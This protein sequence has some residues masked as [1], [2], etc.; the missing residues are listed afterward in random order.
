MWDSHWDLMNNP[1]LGVIKKSLLLLTSHVCS[2]MSDSF[3]TPETA[4]HQAPLSMGFSRYEYWSGLPFP[5]PGGLSNTGIELMYPALAG[6]FFTT[7]PPGKW[8]MTHASLNSPLKWP[9]EVFGSS[10]WKSDSGI[11]LSKPLK[12][13]IFSNEAW[14]FRKKTR[15]GVNIGRA[16]HLASQ[17]S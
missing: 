8:L 10:T 12:E 6:G 15:W 13:V 4:F 9:S 16:T 14:N 1:I 7:Y 11:C 5:S 2:L 17:M 3:A